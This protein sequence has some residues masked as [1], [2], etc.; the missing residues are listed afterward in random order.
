MDISRRMLSLSEERYGTSLGF[1]S[2]LSLDELRGMS[3][4][5]PAKVARIKAEWFPKEALPTVRPEGKPFAVRWPG[6]IRV[7]EGRPCRS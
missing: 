1:L 3:G 7:R 5:G 6:R 2:G 4:V